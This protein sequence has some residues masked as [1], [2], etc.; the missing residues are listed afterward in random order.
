MI[1]AKIL[2]IEEKNN[3]Y[4][5]DIVAKSEFI[6]CHAL[7]GGTEN[8]FKYYGR[9]KLIDSAFYKAKYDSKKNELCGK[10]IKI[11]K[12]GSYFIDDTMEGLTISD[13][14]ITDHKKTTSNPDMIRLLLKDYNTNY[15]ESQN[16]IRVRVDGMHH[17]HGFA[18]AAAID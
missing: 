12:E 5:L 7:S 2:N 15:R 13:Y 9:A 8:V 4:F 10:H 18:D 1:E 3:S 14:I 6:G 16:T 11:T 17:S